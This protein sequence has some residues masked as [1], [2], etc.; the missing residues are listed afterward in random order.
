MRHICAHLEQ[1]F[2][3]AAQVSRAVVNESDH[4]R[5]IGP[6]RSPGKQR[7]QL[8]TFPTRRTG[9][10]ELSLLR[11]DFRKFLGASHGNPSKCVIFGRPKHLC[12]TYPLF[13]QG[14]VW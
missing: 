6:G 7:S 3:Y 10:A 13:G 11:P 8:R 12:Q 4:R 14:E 5:S 1:G 2:V 9:L